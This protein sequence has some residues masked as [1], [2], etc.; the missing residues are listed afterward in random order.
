MP[1]SGFDLA[2]WSPLD[3]RHDNA[4]GDHDVD[5]GDGGLRGVPTR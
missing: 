1:E 3:V 2:E 5:G 4:M